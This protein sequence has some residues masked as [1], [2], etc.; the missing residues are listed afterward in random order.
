MAD[1]SVVLPA[2]AS[3]GGTEPAP[4]DAP[5]VQMGGTLRVD[6][7]DVNKPVV[8]TPKV[9]NPVPE[10]FR[11]ADGSLDADALLK[12]YTEL[13]SKQGNKPA[14]ETPKTD[15]TTTDLTKTLN[16]DALNELREE[17]KKNGKISDESLTKHKIE[18]SAVDS[19]IEGQK[20]LVE[21]YTTTLQTHV[22]GKDAYDAL[23]KWAQANVAEGEQEQIDALLS[24]GN[25]TTAKL[26]LDGLKARFEKVMGKTPDLIT[27]GEGTPVA[28]AKP[29]KSD[30]EMT[31]MI[32]DKRYKTDPAFRKQVEDRLNVTNGFRTN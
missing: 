30:R 21:K 2:T 14:V 9:E 12:S 24:S 31:D 5:V 27:G 16:A 32:S 13:E 3:G 18:R 23:V 17:F 4:S 11:K 6:A 28:G 29:F 8:D 19:Y 22:G 1:G 25:E 7:G 15:A 10:K 20:A 26:A